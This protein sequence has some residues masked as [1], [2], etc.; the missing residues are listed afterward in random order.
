MKVC[1]LASGS[2]GNSIFIGNENCKILIDVGVSCKQ[3]ELRL[4]KIEESLSEINAIFITHEHSDHIAG[5]KVINKRFNIPIFISKNS[6]C[7][8]YED[9]KNIIFF[10]PGDTIDFKKFKIKTFS[11]PHDALDPA[12]FKILYKEHSI[13]VSTDIGKPTY[14]IKETLRDCDTVF[15]EFN[16]DEDMLINGSY[17][18]ELKQRIKS[19]MGHLSNS[20]ALEILKDIEAENIFI[21]HISEENNSE[22]KIFK[23][24]EN[25][26]NKN[27]FFTYQH[28]VSKVLLKRS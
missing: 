20:Q 19:N 12:G 24:I 6:Y 22:E 28:K 26:T 5:L 25:I 3:I 8:K 23:H 18:W 2:K 4:N 1:T 14:L 7:P 27:F 10:N 17:P 13:G 16:H 21:S 11:I 15:L 9:L